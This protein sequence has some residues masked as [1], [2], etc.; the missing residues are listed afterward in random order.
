M[1]TGQVFPLPKAKS[2]YEFQDEIVTRRT[3][4]QHLQDLRVDIVSTR[5]IQGKEGSLALR[6]YQFLLMGAASG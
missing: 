2:Q 6:P 4:E 1:I 3:V 5:D